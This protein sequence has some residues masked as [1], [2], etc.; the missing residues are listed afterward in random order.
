MVTITTEGRAILD[1][2]ELVVDAVQEAFL[3]PLT[4]R[5][6]TLFVRLLGKLT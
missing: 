5:E 6:R 2:L 1:R 3:D 4:A